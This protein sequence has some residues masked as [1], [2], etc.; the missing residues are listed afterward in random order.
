VLTDCSPGQK[1]EEFRSYVKEFVT[2]E[3]APHSKRWD[4]ENRLPW[5]AIKKMGEAGLLGVICPVQL[6]GQGR[7]YVS[8]GVV[9]E[10]IAKA[11]MS[12]AIICWIQATLA[13]LVPGWGD[14]T[15]RAV[16][17]GDEVIALATSEENA[18]S[19]VSGIE[20]SAE[21]D[22]DGYVINGMKIHVSLVPGAQ[23]LGVTARTWAI[24][25]DEGI[26]MFRVRSD[27]PGVSVSPMGQL[28]ARAHQLGRVVLKDVRVPVSATMGKGG[29]GKKVM[30]A[31]FNV[32]RCLSPLAAIGAA[33]ATLDA[34]VEYART[35][36]AFG[37]PIGTNQAISFPIVEHY[38]R[39]EAARMLAYKALS[40]ND[41]GQNAVREAAM[42]KWFGITSGIRAIADCLQMHGANGY[43]T[44]HPLE[45]KLRDVMA[46]QFTG[47]TINIMK[48]LLV[49]EVLGKEFS[50]IA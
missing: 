29:G 30:Y 37:R 22:G 12:C 49:R 20:C 31:R 8:L 2:R 7:D 46:L 26:T 3:I 45:Q 40:M 44:E 41:S 11:D 33:W 4:L 27:C 43:L 21:L 6:G 24:G 9:I 5:D 36:V 15:I 47:G 17:R 13:G 35:K 34:T 18:G 10:E 14:E 16:S 42:A 32:S 39:L 19:D 25:R 48:I 28:G 38:T 1:H 50:G 23:T